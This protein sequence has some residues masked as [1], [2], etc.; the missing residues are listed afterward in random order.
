MNLV[1][2]K[3]IYIGIPMAALIY[4]Y[5]TIFLHFIQESARLSISGSDLSLFRFSF[6]AGS[7]FSPS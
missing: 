3:N 5:V 6:P 4:N 7:C 1:L 2:I